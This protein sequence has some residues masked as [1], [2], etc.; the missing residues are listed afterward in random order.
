MFSLVACN[1]TGS[2]GPQGEQGI[3]GEQGNDGLSAFEIFLKYNP[4]Y[5]GTEQDW[6]KNCRLLS[7]NTDEA[8]IFTGI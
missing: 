5:T 6:I 3:Q 2:Q 7:R 4:E 1:A 8:I